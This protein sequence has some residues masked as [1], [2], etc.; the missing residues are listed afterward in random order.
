LLE[1]A[2]K[3]ERAAW[4]LDEGAEIAPGRSVLKP[5]GGGS[6]YEVYLVWDEPMHAIC[7]AKLIRPD[8]T[9]D[10][11]ALEDLRDEA[12]LVEELAH[13]VI[14]RGFGAVTDGPYPHLLLEHLEGPSLRR[15]IKR[16]GPL[17]LQQLLPLALHVAG[18]LH[19]LQGLGYVHLDVKP[20]NLIMSVPPRLIDLS[21]A[22]SLDRAARATRPLGTDAY[23]APEQCAPDRHPGAV[24]SPADVFGL[25][26]TLFHAVSGSKPYP[27][28]RDDRD[29]EV[30]EERYPQ[31]ARPPID[32]P[33]HLPAGL[34]ELIDSMLAHDPSERPTAG[35]VANR[36]D[37]LIAG[38][39]SK[40][41]L[42][43]RGRVL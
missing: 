19:Y 9:G 24:G 2:V 43:R 4:R 5:I 36:L 26:T 1:T 6:L 20:D 18:A 22:R 10:E 38:L 34:S 31:L 8:Q 12:E 7:V 37:P 39:P 41:T 32:L 15:L 17:P 30:P 29:S 33:D 25:G 16:G 3:T 42:S 35:E 11:Y 40:L 23:M 13:P 27:R 21:I 14:V 28:G